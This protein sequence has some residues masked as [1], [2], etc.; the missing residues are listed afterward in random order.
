ML[1]MIDE[2][3][4]VAQTTT[5]ENVEQNDSNI[6]DANEGVLATLEVLGTSVAEWR[7]LQ[8]KADDKLYSVLDGCLRI[9]Y[10]CEDEDLKAT[11]LSVCKDRGMKGIESKGVHLIVSKLVFGSCDKKCYTYAKALDNASKLKLNTEKDKR[12][13]SEYLKSSGGID[14]LI[15]KEAIAI[16]KGYEDERFGTKEHFGE[17]LST[18]LFGYLSGLNLMDRDKVKED[19]VYSGVCDVKIDN[20][21][22][23][24]KFVNKVETEQFVKLK[25]DYTKK[26]FHI[27]PFC[28]SVLDNEYNAINKAYNLHLARMFEGTKTY[29]RYIAH[30]DKLAEKMKADKAKKDEEMIAEL[31]KLAPL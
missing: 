5:T 24:Q 10:L 4:S 7:K 3:T 11:L 25:Y 18:E 26:T 21:E 28:V 31:N 23:M 6:F 2:K 20:D 1:D 27:L 22:F 13:L 19:K 16:G 17:N 14:A 9:V 29:Q 15:R 30:C 12:T 8:G